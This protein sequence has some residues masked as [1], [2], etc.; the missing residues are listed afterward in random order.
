M[1]DSKSAW[2]WGRENRAGEGRR[3]KFRHKC[4]D[5]PED[6]RP[7]KICSGIQGCGGMESVI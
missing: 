3:A 6:A 7:A 4:L 2:P 5:E 1:I